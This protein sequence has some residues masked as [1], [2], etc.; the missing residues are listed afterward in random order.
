MNIVCYTC[1]LCSQPFANCHQLPYSIELQGFGECVVGSV[2]CGVKKLEELLFC[3]NETVEKLVTQM[4]LNQAETMAGAWRHNPLCGSLV[5][6]PSE[7]LIQRM[8][9]HHQSQID[10]LQGLG[11]SAEEKS[12]IEQL[13][14]MLVK[15]TVVE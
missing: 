3:P 1:V 10:I 11:A 6:R 15:G 13:Q 7:Q 5:F 12:V 2:C 4:P 9:H 14:H 8:L